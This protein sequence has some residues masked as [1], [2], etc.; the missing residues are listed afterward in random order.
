MTTTNRQASEVF[1][2]AF[3]VWGST[4]ISASFLAI[5]Y[6]GAQ[7]NLEYL[8]GMI[9]LFLLFSLVFSIPLFGAALLAIYAVRKTGRPSRQC[10]LLL[11]LLFSVVYIAGLYLLGFRRILSVDDLLLSL[12]IYF[13]TALCF[14]WIFRFP[15]LNQAP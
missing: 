14:T 7:Q 5:L 9:S 3:R 13:I 4:L 8:L 1:N 10:K 11:S 2:Y 12:H 6:Y 15:V